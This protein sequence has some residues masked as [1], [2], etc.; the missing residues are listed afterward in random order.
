MFD[1]G[2]A[3]TM[4]RLTARRGVARRDG[5][6][7]REGS[8]PRSHSRSRSRDTAN[9]EQL[10]VDKGEKGESGGKEEA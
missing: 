4:R 9:R 8:G 10:A 3:H 2:R 5:G 7:G 6:G 1:V